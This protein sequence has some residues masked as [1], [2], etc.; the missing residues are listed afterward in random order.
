MNIVPPVS[1]PQIVVHPAS[2]PTH[3]SGEERRNDLLMHQMIRATVQEGGQE[4]ALLQFGDR[5]LWV[6]SRVALRAG[7]QLNLQ[8]VE[9]HPELKLKILDSGLLERLGR[10]LYLLSEKPDMAALTRDL[11]AR[12]GSSPESRTAN[13]QGLLSSLTRSPQIAASGSGGSAP[14]IAEDLSLLARRLGLGYERQILSGQADQAAASLKSAVLEQ[15]GRMEQSMRT[16]EIG[17]RPLQQALA[18]LP[19]LIPET[20][21]AAARLASL[22]QGVKAVLEPLLALAQANPSGLGREQA[23]ALLTAFGQALQAWLFE[24]GAGSGGIE[25]KLRELAD[26]FATAVANSTGFEARTLPLDGGLRDLLTT[27]L[28]LVRGTPRQLAGA[29]GEEIA[30]RLQSFVGREA[31][32]SV[33]NALEQ[34]QDAL[35]HI[36]LWQMCRARLAEIGVD[37]LPL[38]LSFLERGY[39]LCRRHLEPEGGGGKAQSGQSHSISLFLELEGLGR[40]QI[41]CLYQGQGQGLYLRFSCRDQKVASFL[42]A[43]QDELRQGL[44]DTALL[45]AS[46]SAGAEDPAQALIQRLIPAETHLLDARV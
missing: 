17:L 33:E 37:F 21:D 31:A 25:Q 20:P 27:L 8:V 39:L 24:A 44:G 11:A 18:Q 1:L 9:T 35:R 46:F 38:P 36:E 29:E 32:S 12:S 5:T 41:D 30:R 40:L 7:E 28:R 43:A 22:P 15:L 10:S 3:L 4:K 26:S 14:Q 23:A 6:Q 16:V 45:A 42:E 34:T 19:Q 13:L 2:Q